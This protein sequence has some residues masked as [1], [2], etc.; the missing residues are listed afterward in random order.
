MLETLRKSMATH[1][2]TDGTNDGSYKSESGDSADETESVDLTAEQVLELFMGLFGKQSNYTAGFMGRQDSASSDGTVNNC[3]VQELSPLNSGESFNSVSSSHSNS[4]N[5]LSS[6]G[7][8]LDIDETVRTYSENGGTVQSRSNSTRSDG[9]NGAPNTAV[10]VA[11]NIG[12]PV[13][14]AAPTASHIPVDRRQGI[15]ESPTA[16]MEGG[17]IA[18]DLE[19]ASVSSSSPF[20]PVS[21]GS[22]IT[23]DTTATNNNN[24]VGGNN[25]NYSST[26]VVLSNNNNNAVALG[27]PLAASKLAEALSKL[28]QVDQILEHLSVFWANT[29]VVLEVLTKKGQHVEQFI[30]F[31]SKP[32]L[33]ARFMERLEEYKRFWEGISYMCNSYISG[34]QQQTPEPARGASGQVTSPPKDEGSAPPKD[35]GPAPQ[36]NTFSN[37]NNCKKM[38]S[39]LEC[40][41]IA[42]NFN[43]I[44]SST[45]SG[46]GSRV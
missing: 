31:A 11:F 15:V 34:V 28:R 18:M 9:G 33:M 39:F 37:A 25:N 42:S 32:R 7:N 36:N 3:N 20:S 30:G 16:H 29:E 21:H 40:E 19:A 45:R 10:R 17:G 4:T 44:M 1:R 46:S 26:D 12:S 27:S 23:V 8:S 6:R 35:V 13:Q 2:I 41:E 43:N 38:Y 24:F 5:K 14:R 22:Q